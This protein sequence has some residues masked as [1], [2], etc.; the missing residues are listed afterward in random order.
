MKIKDI[1]NIIK[2]DT[3]IDIKVKSKCRDANFLRY[4]FVTLCYMYA[5]E[6]VQRSSIIEFFPNKQGFRFTRTLN[7]FKDS[8]LFN[9]EDSKQFEYLNNLMKSKTQLRKPFNDA[10]FIKNINTL[11]YEYNENEKLR[12]ENEKLIRRNQE[13]AIKNTYLSVYKQRLKQLEYG[14]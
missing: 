5:D 11:V 9:K 14:K 3:G 10:E 13:L 12:K 8:L 4:S 1:Y 2:E 6:Y 7:A